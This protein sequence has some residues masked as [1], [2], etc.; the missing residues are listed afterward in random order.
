MIKHTK[1]EQNCVKK[2]HMSESNA[3]EFTFS[4]LY[5]LNSFHR[6]KYYSLIL[7]TMYTDK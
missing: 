6:V 4:S 3:E 7:Y 5:L 1:T 2:S